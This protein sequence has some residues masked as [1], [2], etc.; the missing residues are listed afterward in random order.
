LDIII[1]IKLYNLISVQSCNVNVFGFTDKSSYF[2]SVEFV[3][4]FRC[5]NRE[6]RLKYRANFGFAREQC[7][8]V[9]NACALKNEVL[10]NYEEKEAQEGHRAIVEERCGK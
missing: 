4:L 10:E 1:I 5:N 9:A 7:A 8:Y 6:C 3:S 2:F